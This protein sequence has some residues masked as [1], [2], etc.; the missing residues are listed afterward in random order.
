MIGCTYGLAKQNKEL[1]MKNHGI[2]PA[3]TAPL[4]KVNALVHN[5]YGNEKYRDRDF[6][7]GRSRGRRGRRGRGCTSNCYHDV[8]KSGTSNYQKKN[9]NEG[10]ERCGQNH[11]SKVIENLFY[12]YG[13]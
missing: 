9:R 3:S 6:G 4:P 8:Y 7:R 1:L 11:P 12:R 10:Q 13:M 5:K 2:H